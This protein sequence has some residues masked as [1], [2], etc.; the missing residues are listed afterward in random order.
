M[1]TTKKVEIVIIRNK[2]T[3]YDPK[4]AALDCQHLEAFLRQYFNHKF[5]VSFPQITT[6]VVVRYHQNEL[7]KLLR[8][9]N[10]D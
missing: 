6:M 4:F 9:Q 2:L 10:G 3:G 8:K 1:Q 5:L 7:E